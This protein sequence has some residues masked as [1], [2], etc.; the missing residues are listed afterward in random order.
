MIPTD[1]VPTRR[2]GRRRPIRYGHGVSGRGEG[3]AE[4]A[5]LRRAAGAGALVARAGCHIVSPP[6]G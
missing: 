5:A 6:V 4:D 2:P 1:A 3:L